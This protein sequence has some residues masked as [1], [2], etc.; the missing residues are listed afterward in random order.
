MDR[1]EE[2]GEQTDSYETYNSY[3]GV[4]RQ[5]DPDQPNAVPHTP[6]SQSASY[7]QSLSMQ[8]DQ[9]RNTST[10]DNAAVSA[11]MQLQGRGQSQNQ[12]RGIEPNENQPRTST[13]NMAN[14][15]N[16]LGRYQS[17][18]DTEVQGQFEMQTRN[19][20]QALENPSIRYSDSTIKD[21]SSSLSTTISSMQ[22]QQA[23]ADSSIKDTISS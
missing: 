6:V 7:Q 5:S 14:F 18:S 3:T 22:Q 8:Y 11:L 19:R 21:T 2:I 1:G 23:V 4:N 9:S 13:L 12:V 17:R 20:S 10:D 16:N 15:Y